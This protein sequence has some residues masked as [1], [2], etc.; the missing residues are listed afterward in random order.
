[1]NGTIVRKTGDASGKYFCMFIAIGDHV[2]DN[3]LNRAL[4]E[5]LSRQKIDFRYRCVLATLYML[6]E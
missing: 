5:V 4:L 3:E 2:H 6:W 1:M